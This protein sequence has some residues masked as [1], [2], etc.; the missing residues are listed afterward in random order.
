M[1]MMLPMI[2]FG[3]LAGAWAAD[4]SGEYSH[5]HNTFVKL[6]TQKKLRIVLIGNSI[7]HGG[8]QNG[9]AINYYQYLVDWLQQRF[10]QAQIEVQSGVIFAIGAEVEVF[11]MEDKVFAPKADLVVA[12]FNA[13]NGGEVAAWGEARGG[14]IGEAATEGFLR[15]LRF[16]MP[17]T[18]CLLNMSVSQPMWDAYYSK[19]LVPPSVAFHH[20]V[21]AHYGM[22][23]VDSGQAIVD[24]LRAGEPWSTYMN[25]VVHPGEKGYAL[26]GATIIAELERQYALFLATPEHARKLRNYPMPATT[27]HPEPWL[28]P[29]LVPAFYADKADGFTVGECGRVKYLQATQAGAHGVFTA[30]R[31]QIVGLYLRF[32]DYKVTT[33]LEVRPNGRG[34]WVP[35][36]SET[37]VRFNEQDDGEN[38]FNRFFLHAYGMPL[39]CDSIEFR[40]PKGV[41]PATLQITG[42]FV[43]E[44]PAQ[45]PFQRP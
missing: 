24:R 9:K 14:A 31:G 25:D 7:T 44:R 8:I 34:K 37:E 15:R 32:K 12:E 10:P 26:H 43:I 27:I 3:C 17:Q 21:S 4:W 39:G 1:R 23:E 18:D 6:S 5:M 28:F 13:A 35:L 42:F 41:D 36:S 11:R 20:R 22:P 16:Y 38:W 30:K 45:M 19:N 40:L 33:K 2:L 29:R